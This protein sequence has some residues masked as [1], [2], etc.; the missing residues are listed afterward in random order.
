MSPILSLGIF[1]GPLWNL[2][3]TGLWTRSTNLGCSMVT[4]MYY[5]QPVIWGRGYGSQ[6]QFLLLAIKEFHCLV[7]AWIWVHKWCPLAVSSH[8]GRTEL[9]PQ[10]LSYKDTDPNSNHLITSHRL[11]LQ[12]LSPRGWGFQHMNLGDTKTQTE[13]WRFYW[14]EPIK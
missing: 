14:G 4:Q 6:N 3:T 8:G 1:F 9:S 12:I 13:R 2:P 10:G 11:S 7:R 5:Y